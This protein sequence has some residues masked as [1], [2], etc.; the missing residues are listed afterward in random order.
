[1]DGSFGSVIATDIVLGGQALV[2]IEA[3]DFAFESIG[4]K[5]WVL[6]GEHAAARSEP[7]N[8]NPADN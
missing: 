8:R 3:T 6:Q 7:P 4:C 1:M 5:T 2:Q